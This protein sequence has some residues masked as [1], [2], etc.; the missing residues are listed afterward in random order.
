MV[1]RVSRDARYCGRS[2]AS[3][4]PTKDA[5]RVAWVNLLTRGGATRT[6]IRAGWPASSEVG[7]ANRDASFA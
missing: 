6:P 2:R 7:D 5:T 4:C 3:T 1:T